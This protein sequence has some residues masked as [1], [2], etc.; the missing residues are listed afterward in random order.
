[1]K[2]DFSQSAAVGASASL[3]RDHLEQDRMLV[4][5]VVSRRCRW[6]QAAWEVY[7]S[8]NWSGGGDATKCFSVKKGVFSEKGEAIQ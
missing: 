8:L 7:K 3:L 1:M 5:A 4:A 2:A 6:R